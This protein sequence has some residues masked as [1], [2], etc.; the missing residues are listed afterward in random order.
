VT[1]YVIKTIQWLKGGERNV[2]RNLKKDSNLL[3]KLARRRENVKKVFQ[4]NGEG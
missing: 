4:A 3:E 2:E 1:I